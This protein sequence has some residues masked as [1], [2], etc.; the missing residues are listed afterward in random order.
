MCR[1]K[2]S[3]S[4]SWRLTA[5]GLVDAALGSLSQ[6]IVVFTDVFSCRGLEFTT[7]KGTR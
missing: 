3:G 6:P 1:P 5:E 2:N 7:Q 4:I